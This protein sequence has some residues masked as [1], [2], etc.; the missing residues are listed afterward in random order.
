M[1]RIQST[2]QCKLL[3]NMDATYYDQVYY[4]MYAGFRVKIY[5][6]NVALIVFQIT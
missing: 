4:S 5:V 6:D 2:V 3:S 1:Y